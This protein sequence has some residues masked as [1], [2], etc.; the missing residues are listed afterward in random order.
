[1]QIQAGN[2]LW[3]STEHVLKGTHRGVSKL[4][5]LG[6]C[7][8]DGEGDM[9]DV[10]PFVVRPAPSETRGIAVHFIH[11]E[12]ETNLVVWWHLLL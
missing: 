12:P 1:M 8:A 5:A 9:R 2:R 7:V 6:C 11:L 3:V 10:I 4:N